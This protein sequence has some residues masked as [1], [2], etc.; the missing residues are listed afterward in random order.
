MLELMWGGSRGNW[1]PSSSS[2]TLVCFS[3][4]GSQWCIL[5]G[6]RS[7]THTAV[8]LGKSNHVFCETSYQTCSSPNTGCSFSS[9]S[10]HRA[11]W[12]KEQ[13][14]REKEVGISTFHKDGT[15]EVYLCWFDV[16]NS[17]WYHFIFLTSTHSAPSA[18]TTWQPCHF[19]LTE[20]GSQKRGLQIQA[21]VRAMMHVFLTRSCPVCK[22][23]ALVPLL[24]FQLFPA[25]FSFILTYLT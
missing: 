15:Q 14:D 3:E 5:G 22:R 20:W 24:Y 12:K 19:D 25:T 4:M 9:F 17:L 16:C 21:T 1:K 11:T 13:R 10:G 23:T 18:L 7:G 8:A 2:R 6:Q